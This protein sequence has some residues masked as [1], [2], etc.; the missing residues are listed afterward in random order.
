MQYEFFNEVFIYVKERQ[1]ASLE[2]FRVL[3]IS[4][5]YEISS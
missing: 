2:G 5:G 3:E 4:Q 1:R